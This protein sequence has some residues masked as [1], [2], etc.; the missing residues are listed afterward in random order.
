M[1]YTLIKTKNNI[2]RLCRTDGCSATKMLEGVHEHR[3]ISSA[4]SRKAVTVKT[5]FAPKQGIIFHEGEQLC[6]QNQ[7]LSWLRSAVFLV[8]SCLSR[9]SVLIPARHPTRPVLS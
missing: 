9:L 5:C 2:N 1:R 7:F 8:Q 4:S 6:Q 3:D